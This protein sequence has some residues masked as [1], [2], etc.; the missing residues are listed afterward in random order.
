MTTR[1]FFKAT[2]RDFFPVFLGAFVGIGGG[3]GAVG[4]KLLLDLSHFSAWQVSGDFPSIISGWST[5]FILLIPT[6]GGLVVGLLTWFLA[7]EAKGHG[8]PEVISAIVR[9]RGIIRPRVVLVKA[10]ASAVCI[11]TGGSCG[12]EGPIAQIGSA[13]GSMVGQWM[14]WKRDR[15]RVLVGSGAAAGISA[16]FNAPVAGVIFALEILLRDFSLKNLTPIIV[17]GVMAVTVSHTLLPEHTIFTIPQYQVNHPVELL[18]YALLGLGAAVVGVS[19]IRCLYF[20]EDVGDRIPLPGWLK[21][22]LGGLGIGTMA[23]VVPQV[24]GV[25]YT[26]VS[27]ALDPENTTVLAAAGLGTVAAVTLLGCWPPRSWPPPSPSAWGDRAVSLPRP[28][29]WVPCTAAWWDS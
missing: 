6:A 3:L 1:P 18:F 28:F 22:A 16:T 24:M 9:K 4:F 13:W 26:T 14:P 2:L 15:V 20:M 8:V 5:V 27:A 12:R 10:L 7:R 19:F 25:G 17:S 29:S 23:L 11:G 21:P